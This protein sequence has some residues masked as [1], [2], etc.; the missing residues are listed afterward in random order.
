MKI[1]N[2]VLLI[3]S[4]VFAA[5]SHA[6]ETM[7]GP[8]GGRMLPALPLQVEFHVMPDLRAEIIFYDLDLKPAAPGAATVTLIAEPAGGRSTIELEPT[9]TG[10]VSK[11]ALPE[12]AP[13]RVVVQV[14]ESAGARPQNFR[15]DLNLRECGECERAEYACTCEGH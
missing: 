2:H 12:G 11:T 1:I 14:R 9:D 6:A 8:K 15:V 10:F 13:Y 7:P 5:A 4:F 3:A